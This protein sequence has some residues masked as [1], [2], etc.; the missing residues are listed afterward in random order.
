M[1]MVQLELVV[2]NPHLN[3]QGLR[4]LLLAVHLLVV[5]LI[6]I[7]YNEEGMSFC[8]PFHENVVFVGNIGLQMD[9]YIVYSSHVSALSCIDKIS[10]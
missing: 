8:F 4:L 6:K 1:G 9:G 7:S 3:D 2:F 10:L 5:S